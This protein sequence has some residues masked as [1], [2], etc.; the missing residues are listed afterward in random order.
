MTV[1]GSELLFK[2]HR[3]FADTTC[4]Q[5]DAPFPTIA[6][7]SFLYS[8]FTEQQKSGSSSSSV[9][10]L[11]ACLGEFIYNQPIISHGQRG[12]GRESERSE[13]KGS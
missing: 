13:T 6:T 7:A 1:R 3:R 4:I 12:E 5:T 8:D 10:V 2:D 9:V 11:P